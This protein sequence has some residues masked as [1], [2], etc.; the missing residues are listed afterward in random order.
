MAGN[1]KRYPAAAVGHSAGDEIIHRCISFSVPSTHACHKVFHACLRSIQEHI[2]YLSRGLII[3]IQGTCR[4]EPS[5][6]R[7]F[8]NNT[9]NNTQCGWQ[10]P[11]AD[12][13]KAACVF[14]KVWHSLSYRWRRSVSVFQPQDLSHL[15]CGQ[16]KICLLITEST[17][18]SLSG[19]VTMSLTTAHRLYRVFLNLLIGNVAYCFINTSLEKYFNRP[20]FQ[21]NRRG[22]GQSI[23]S[24]S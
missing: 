16:I 11:I 23:L 7:T 10:T 22:H 8:E 12:P 4:R 6:S 24:A 13:H 1:G 2:G 9:I 18:T 19:F 15:C 21:A 14:G 5:I 3:C 17:T 20:V